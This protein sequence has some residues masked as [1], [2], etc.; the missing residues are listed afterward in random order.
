M[1]I[2]NQIAVQTICTLSSSDAIE[3]CAAAKSVEIAEWMFWLTLVATCLSFLSTLLLIAT[4]YLA[5]K[6]TDAATESTKIAAKAIEHAERTSIKEMRPNI[7]PAWSVGNH[8]NDDTWTDLFGYTIRIDW[9]N[10]GLSTAYNARSRIGWQIFDRGSFPTDFDFNTYDM[11]SPSAVAPDGLL[12]LEVIISKEDLMKVWENKS[13]IHIWSCIQY[14]GTSSSEK[15]GCERHITL[16]PRSM[17]NRKDV[18]FAFVSAAGFNA[19]DY[20]CTFKR[21]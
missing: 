13:E 5:K 7:T 12:W 9:I 21:F 17:P 4:V 6:A 11:S 15:Y 14:D 2:L 10:K 18:P 3:A 8:W 16:Q 19:I 20:E 1:P